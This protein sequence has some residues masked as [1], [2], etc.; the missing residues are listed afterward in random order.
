MEALH[1]LGIEHADRY[2]G[3]AIYE[4]LRMRIP[5]SR[6]LC[7]DTLATLAALKERGYLL[8]VVT[9]RHYGGEPFHEDLQEMGLLDYID[10]AHMAI[11]A[12]LGIRKPHPEIFM[13]ALRSLNVAPQEAAMVGDQLRADIGG[14]KALH[15]QAI[16]KPKPRCAKK[17]DRH[18]HSARA[19]LLA[20]ELSA[21]NTD[22]AAQAE[23]ELPDPYMLS[24]VLDREEDLS[25]AL[26]TALTP[27]A[28]IEHLSD[29][30]TL[31]P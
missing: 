1:D 30:L 22:A 29:L 24:Y 3:A 28:I 13:H 15:I 11:S 31:F 23:P 21:L 10:Y 9:N 20:H 7:A 26:R 4:A 14:A 16:W 17:P 18:L 12:D 27:D 5:V 2:M 19:V 6:V 8:G 25:P